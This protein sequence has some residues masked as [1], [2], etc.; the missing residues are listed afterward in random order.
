MHEARRWRSL[1]IASPCLSRVSEVVTYLG[2]LSETLMMDSLT[3]GPMGRTVL[4]VDDSS[5]V[6][7][8]TGPP[9]MADFTAARS[10]FRKMNV[11]PAVL[12]VDTY[13][14]AFS[15]TIFSQHLTTLEVYTGNHYTH[16]PDV[17]EWH[18]I[19]SHTS[20][21]AR[22]CLWSPR[23]RGVTNG[24][25]P[26]TITI[27][28]FALEHLEL[29]GAFITL[30]S[31]FVES[32]LPRLDYLLLDFLG[33]S[34]DI[35]G[36]LARFGL[37]SPALTQL[38]IGSMSFNPQSSGGE[39]NKWG[40]AFRSLGSLQTLTLAEMEWREA[41]NALW[42][43]R[44]LSDESFHVELREIWDMDMG[45]LSLLL[46]IYG[47]SSVV[48]VTDCL[49]GKPGPCVDSNHST[50]CSCEAGSNCECW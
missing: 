40:K 43:L 28:L 14:V 5:V 48:Q 34:I 25:L 24:N 4:V 41:A 2:S 22:L 46:E 31:L 1:D 26:T 8:P 11:R 37:V 9:P 18:Q 44:E 47:D 6:S 10:L 20:Q 15:P 42:Q 16:L 32:P 39:A 21:L 36:Q 49:E 30:S 45:E 7:N 29:S 27:K 3:V 17:V 13:P 35:P 38:Y 23:H 50:R 19:L 33:V 12:H